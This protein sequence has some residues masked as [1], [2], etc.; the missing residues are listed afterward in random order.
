MD[1][2]ILLSRQP[3]VAERMMRA[4]DMKGDLP[5]NVDAK[6]RS[7]ILV[8]DLTGAE[9]DFLRRTSRWLGAARTAAVAAQYG[10]IAFGFGAAAGERG[11]LA[12]ET[13]FLNNENAA[14]I[15]VFVGVTASTIALTTPPTSPMDDRQY[16]AAAQSGMGA[17]GT[18]VSAAAPPFADP[19]FKVL[20]AANSSVAVTLPVILTNKDPGSASKL[21]LAMHTGAVN[22]TLSVALVWREG[23]L[24]SGELR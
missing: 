1:D 11:L 16:V 19:N 8:E 17:F 5:E 12:V 10:T 20:V 14:Q 15:V 22:Q 18:L 13:L 3:A 24:V 2:V 21:V 4:L 23:A 7:T 6:F 9:Y